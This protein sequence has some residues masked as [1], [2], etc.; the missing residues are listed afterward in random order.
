MRDFPLMAQV[1][2]PVV[3]R[4]QLQSDTFAMSVENKTTGDKELSDSP[5]QY[6]YWYTKK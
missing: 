1:K 2:L 5:V 3:N 4:I 6:K